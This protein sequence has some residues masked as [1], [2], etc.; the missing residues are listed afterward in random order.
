MGGEFGKVVDEQ[1]ELEMRDAEEI[2][3]E[4]GSEDNRFEAS[5]LIEYKGYDW[6]ISLRIDREKTSDPAIFNVSGISKNHRRK[7]ICSRLRPKIP[8][9]ID[10]LANA[11]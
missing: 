1:E 11:L 8:I 3:Q 9:K 6:C 4:Y 10:T 7:T 5:E 2:I